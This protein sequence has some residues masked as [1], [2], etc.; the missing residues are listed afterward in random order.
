MYSGSSP[1]AKRAPGVGVPQPVRPVPQPGPRRPPAQPEEPRVGR[2]L[3]SAAP[4][5]PRPPPTGSHQRGGRSRRSVTPPGVR[6]STAPCRDTDDRHPLGHDPPAAVLVRLQQGPRI[7]LRAPARQRVRRLGP[8][9]VPAPEDRPV[10]R[11][12]D[13]QLGAARTG[14]SRRPGRGSTS[15]TG[16]GTR[17][18]SAPRAGSPAASAR[19]LRHA[20]RTVRNPCTA[21]EPIAF[22]ERTRSRPSM[23]LSLPLTGPIRVSSFNFRSPVVGAHLHVAD[24]V[25]RTLVRKSI[26]W[27]RPCQPRH[28][29]TPPVRAPRTPRAQSR[30]PPHDLSRTPAPLWQPDPERIAAGPDHHVPGLGRRAARSPRR[31]R[32][33]RPAPLVRRRARNVLAGRHRV[34]R[35]PLLHP[36]RARARR[37][38]HARR[39]V[40]PRRHPQLR[41]ARPARRRRPRADEPAL[42]HVDE[43]HEP[44]PVTWSELRR[45]V[46]SL[47]AELRALGVRPGDRVSGYLPN[48]PA[49]RRRPPR[50]GRRR[51]ASGPPA[52]PTSAPA[53][54]STASSRSNP[55]SCSPSTA[56]A[57]AARSTTA[58]TPSPN[59]AANCPPC[60]PSSTSRCSAPSAPE[61]ALDWSALTSARHRARLRAGALR[62]PAVGALLLR[63]DRP[64]QGHRPVPG[65][66]PR[67]STSSSS[68]CT[69]TSAPRTASSGTPPP[70]G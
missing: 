9:P 37:S 33:P 16:P 10:H 22:T 3:A 45:Q 19:L 36:L 51:R 68:A 21:A 25:R 63:H 57:T 38:R 65:R 27:H 26:T 58:A 18:R 41:R 6:T 52:P 53:A 31:G 70:A 4:S 44:R 29:H 17:A 47:A 15:G 40:V 2:H 30:E 61:G 42:L 7:R 14:R 49:G 56:T 35:R 55:S 62:P 23:L 28:A 13:P 54:S 46:G 24:H 64:A 39:P 60:A 8:G 66:H 5:A 12:G 67:S 43:T 20:A 11:D 50:H 32:L 69:A 1:G 59:C 48:I 34:V